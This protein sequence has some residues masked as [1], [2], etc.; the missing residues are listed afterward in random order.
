M[1]AGNVKELEL[2]INGLERQNFDLKMQIYYLNQKLSDLQS[3]LDEQDIHRK[4]KEDLQQAHLR[5]EELEAERLLKQSSLDEDFNFAKEQLPVPQLFS[6]RDTAVI[7]QLKKDLDD[8]NKARVG[9][10][11]LIDEL[12]QQ[13]AAYA[14]EKNELI[15]LLSSERKKSLFYKNHVDV[16]VDLLNLNN[17]SM[18]RPVFAE[19]ASS[20]SDNTKFE[21]FLSSSTKTAAA[22]DASPED[23]LDFGANTAWEEL[24]AL[25]KENQNLVSQ[26][27]KQ[28]DLVRVQEEALR[29]VQ[30]SAEEIGIMEA[31][32]IGRLET[33]LEQAQAEAKAWE[34]RCISAEMRL[35]YLDSSRG[36]VFPVGDDWDSTQPL[37]LSD[38]V[39]AAFLLS[40]SKPTSSGTS[41]HT[42]PVNEIQVLK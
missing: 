2:K 4:C 19:D 39:E 31:E 20:A 10:A 34:T 25:R 9:D 5:I 21:Y 15:A 42:D 13:I 7:E 26:L 17:I 6:E 29:R 37:S 12:T 33:E 24:Q 3:G 30:R 18:A 40:S 11:A 8:I 23:F 38:E 16:Q 22:A 27:R 1:S 41:S 35:S 32:E 14:L 28:I 36:A